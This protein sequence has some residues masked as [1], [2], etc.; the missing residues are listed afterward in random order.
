[1]ILTNLAEVPGKTV[2]RHYGLVYGSSVKVIHIGR[3][4]L[5]GFKNLWGG[6]IKSYSQLLEDSREYAVN[7]MKEE[8]KEK[9]ANAVI[10]VYFDSASIA[11]GTV[12]V[13]V[14]GSAVK[15]D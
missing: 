9:G 13:L 4:F 1:M 7:K 12:E 6:E 10:Q 14:Y 15:L 11:H 2:I 3:N 5:V 8:A